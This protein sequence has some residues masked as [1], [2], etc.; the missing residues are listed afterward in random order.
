MQPAESLNLASA[1][2][3]KNTQISAS[4]K[5]PEDLTK[6]CCLYH[7]DSLDMY[8]GVWYLNMKWLQ[9]Q[10]SVQ[11]LQLFEMFYEKI[12]LR[13]CLTNCQSFWYMKNLLETVAFLPQPPKKY[14]ANQPK[15]PTTEP[16][17]QSDHPEVPELDLL[18]VPWKLASVSCQKIFHKSLGS[19]PIFKP[20]SEWKAIWKGSHN[21]KIAQNKQKKE[22][23]VFQP[24][25]F[26]NFWERDV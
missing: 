15:R 4:E 24:S 7:V 1:P 16:T 10:K 22:R 9:N 13:A 2:P 26:L 21:S 8:E 3:A 6:K 17:D 18:N 25:F 12:P 20:W 5:W 23:L 11:K 19:P 14:V